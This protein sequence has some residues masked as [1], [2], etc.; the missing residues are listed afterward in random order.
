MSKQFTRWLSSTV[1]GSTWKPLLSFRKNGLNTLESDNHEWAFH[2]TIE[3][4]TWFFRV[5]VQLQKATT[6]KKKKAAINQGLC[7][8]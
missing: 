1:K 2:G 3:E 8:D 7:H 5:A 4:I 6:K